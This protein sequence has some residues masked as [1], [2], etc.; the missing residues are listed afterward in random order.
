MLNELTGW[1]G[2]FWIDAAIALVCI[3]FTLRA[4]PESRDPN[5]ARTIDLAGTALVAAALV[6]FVFAMT[7]GSSWGWLSPPTLLCLVLSALA[8]VG[9]VVVE[10]RVAAPLV[11]LGL[12]RN[13]LLVGSTGAILIGAGAIAA[14][15]FLV[16]L[17]FQ[18]PQTLGMTSLQ[19]G[20]ATLP[21]AAV[22]V[23]VAPV[24][25]PLAYYFGA[26]PVV[27]AGFAILTAAFVALAAVRPSW[28]YGAF[29]LP[30]LGIAVGLALSNSPASSVAT[31]SVSRE[32]VGAASGISNMARYVG[33]AVMT[34]VVAGIYAQ[35]AVKSATGGEPLADAL[36]TGLSR[37]SIA[38]AAF[39]A[40]GVLLALLVAR[41]PEKPRLGDYAA[42]A[43]ATTHTLPTT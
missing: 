11:D 32:Q 21:I 12:L 43:T 23:L 35:V 26:R 8:V 17:Y 41:R 22:V 40:A 10:R 39:S 25:A 1:Q 16:S 14:L 5:R 3:P 7:E 6:P 20:L 29:V 38:L 19:A 13:A 4:V 28:D 24:V 15:S 2:L 31:A 42:A 34:A 30:L 27:V 36:A 37:A 18:A 9:F 33:G